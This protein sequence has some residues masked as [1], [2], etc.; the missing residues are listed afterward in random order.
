MK[1]YMVLITTLLVQSVFSQRSENTDASTKTH[2]NAGTDFFPG[3]VCESNISGGKV[4]Q[5]VG[6]NTG[7][8]CY[9]KIGP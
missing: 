4:E 8:L 9:R 6:S 5:N 1:I 3:A 7:R 2:K